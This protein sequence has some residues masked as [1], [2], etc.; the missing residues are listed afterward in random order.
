MEGCGH[1]L[2][3]AHGD[4]IFIFALGGDDFYV[5]PYALDFWCADENHLDRGLAEQA[6]PYGA[7]E[8][9]AIGVAANTDVE[10]AETGLTGIFD[11]FGEK[12]CTGASAEGRQRGSRSRTN[13]SRRP[14]QTCFRPCLSTLT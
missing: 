14:Q 10:C 4:G 1:D 7:L 5:L 6:F 12:D 13:S 9:A 2:S 8:L 11:L 3:L